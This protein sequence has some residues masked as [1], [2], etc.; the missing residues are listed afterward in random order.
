MEITMAISFNS[1][2]GFV[3]GA[4]A[5]N[6]NRNFTEN[7]LERLSSGKRINGAADDAAGLAVL[8]KLEAALSGKEQA[9]KNAADGQ[10][11]L[12]TAEAGAAEVSNILNRMRELAV[13]AANGTNSI[14]EREALQSEADQ[15]T[16][17]I[18]R[19]ADSTSFN[20]RAPLSGA[21]VDVQAG[22]STGENINVTIDAVGSSNLQLDGGRVSFDTSANARDAIGVIDAALE[23]VN[24]VRSDIGASVN[25]IS[26]SI[27][28]LSNAAKNTKIAAG[29]VSDTDVEEETTR[30][31][32]SQIL[33]QS[34]IAMLAQGNASKGM[35]LHLI[36]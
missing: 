5:S 7:P 24:A 36:S 17:E 29:R 8:S 12:H 28:H 15:L 22:A 33:Q 11:L 10:G 31:T 35:M 18:S 4:S 2:P 16:A 20:G 1:K 25:R 21:N 3:L 14:A 27:D 6:T 30:L 26:S 23:K 13:Q 9:I 34:S 19:I 32:K